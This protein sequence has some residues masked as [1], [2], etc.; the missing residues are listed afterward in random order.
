MLAIAGNPTSRLRMWKA[1]IGTGGS[2]VV[3]RAEFHGRQVAVKV[4]RPEAF[5]GGTATVLGT[6]DG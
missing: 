5:E 3:Y 4:P 6:V 2:A 1:A